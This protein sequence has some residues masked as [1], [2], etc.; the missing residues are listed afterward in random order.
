MDAAS[1]SE[2]RDGPALDSD[3]ARTPV[4]IPTTI[5]FTVRTYNDTPSLFHGERFVTYLNNEQATRILSY[6]LEGSTVRL[7]LAADND[8]GDLPPNKRC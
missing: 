2:R 6:I 5:Y 7:R 4:S 8:G 3:R 1:D